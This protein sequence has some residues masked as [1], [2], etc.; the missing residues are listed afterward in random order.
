MLQQPRRM[1]EQ[2][3][4]GKNG[5]CANIKVSIHKITVISY[6]PYSFTNHVKITIRLFTFALAL[7]LLFGYSMMTGENNYGRLFIGL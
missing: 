5:I 6:V 7:V 4:S 3:K 1:E 2:L